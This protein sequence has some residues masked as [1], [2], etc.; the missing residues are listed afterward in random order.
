MHASSTSAKANYHPKPN[1]P[2]GIL[3]GASTVVVAR[4]YVRVSCDINSKGRMQ[5]RD[6]DRQKDPGLFSLRHSLLENA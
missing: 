4:V 6:R 5:A 3:S 2:H 1:A